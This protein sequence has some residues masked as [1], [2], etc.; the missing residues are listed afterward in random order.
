MNNADLAPIYR[1]CGRR[2][3][4]QSALTGELMVTWRVLGPVRYWDGRRWQPVPARKERQLLAILLLGGTVLAVAVG[5]AVLSSA[6]GPIVL[7]QSIRRYDGGWAQVLDVLARPMLCGL[8]AA[9]AGWFVGL[10]LA[11]QGYGNL[12]QLVAILFVAVSLNVLL[13]WL[14]MR[15]TWDDLWTR[16]WRLLPERVRNAI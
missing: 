2:Q 1:R 14:W 6:L 7:Y 3:P 11:E 10:Q 13:A 9:G 16:L 8:A 5:V 15:P 12:A 4:A